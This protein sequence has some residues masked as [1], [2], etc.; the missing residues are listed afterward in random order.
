[1]VYRAVIVED[2]PA[3]QLLLARSLSTQG[4]EV[5]SFSTADD[6]IEELAEIVPHLIIT[7]VMLPGDTDGTEFVQQVRAEADLLGEP[8]VIITTASDLSRVEAAE[9]GADGFWRKPF[10]LWKMIDEA[11]AIVGQRYAHTTRT[12]SPTPLP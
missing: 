2:N 4:Y 3:L 12:H 1:V 6:A 10:D 11:D 7:D 5:I 9:L 8:V